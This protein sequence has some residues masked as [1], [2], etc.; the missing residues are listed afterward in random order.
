MDLEIEFSYKTKSVDVAE[1][2]CFDEAT[3]IHPYF[4]CEDHRLPGRKE[5]AAPHHD[6]VDGEPTMSLSGPLSGMLSVVVGVIEF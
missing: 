6:Q 2:N 4:V 1:V 3:L 5:D